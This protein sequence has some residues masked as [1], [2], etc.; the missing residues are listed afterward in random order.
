MDN[1]RLC[2]DLNVRLDACTDQFLRLIGSHPTWEELEEDDGVTKFKNLTDGGIQAICS[3]ADI[4]YSISTVSEFLLDDRKRKLWDELL[5]DSYPIKIIN[6]KFKITYALYELP[7]P[8]SNRDFVVGTKVK[9]VNDG[10][11]I[12][13]KSVDG[14][15]PENDGIV[16]AE[17]TVSGFYLKEIRSNLTH[18]TYLM[19]ADPKGLIPNFLINSLAE[20]HCAA[21]T[22]IRSA[23]G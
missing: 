23:L 16:R 6:K 12:V 4:C 14:I 18:L 7:W 21:V 2:V 5:L 1:R 20:T 11:I 3:K 17:M 13:S 19:C 8:F 15:V 22:K 9:E 10:L